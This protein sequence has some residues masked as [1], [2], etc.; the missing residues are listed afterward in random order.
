MPDFFQYVLL[1]LAGAYLGSFVSVVAFKHIAGGR[2]MRM[3]SSCLVGKRYNI[4]NLP[5]IGLSG[6]F[7]RCAH[8]DQCPPPRHVIVELALA[9]LLPLAFWRLGAADFSA[10]VPFIILLSIIFLTDLDA[11]IIPD[12]ASLGGAALGLV[13]AALETP[14]LPN[15]HQA[16]V[17]GFSGFGLVYG[18]NALYRLWR[19]TDGIGLGDAKLMGM[20][21]VWLGAPSLL[22]ILFAASAVAA[23]FGTILTAQ[24]GKELEPALVP[25]GCYLVAAALGWLLFAS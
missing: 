18:I 25:F 8:G 22:P 5:L 10:A 19:G 9:G 13:F 12:R 17:G 21:G 1:A 6:Y 2:C 11:L 15:M 24:K 4:E 14:G 23:A 20:L 16:L 3:S 7:W